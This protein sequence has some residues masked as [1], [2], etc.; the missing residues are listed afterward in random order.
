MVYTGFGLDPWIPRRRTTV[1]SPRVNLGQ[2]PRSDLT[3]WMDLVQ[4]AV[5]I[6]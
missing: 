2:I 1:V 6:S 4:I 5:D 3:A